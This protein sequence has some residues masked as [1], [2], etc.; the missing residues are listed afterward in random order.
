MGFPVG[1]RVP[2]GNYDREQGI[3]IGYP[4]GR[5]IEVLP[6]DGMG[7]AELDVDGSG[8][9]ASPGQLS[10]SGITDAERIEVGSLYAPA[11]E[12]WRLPIPHFSPW[13]ANWPWGPPP[14]AV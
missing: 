9:P 6:V 4:N 13:D 5:V 1:V 14:D 2:L 8:I 10:A 3:W 12:L 11:T 7:R